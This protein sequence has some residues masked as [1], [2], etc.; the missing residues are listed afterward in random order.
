MKGT[1]MNEP[2]WVDDDA[3]EPEPVRETEAEYLAAQLQNMKNMHLTLRVQQEALLKGP[4]D[5][6]YPMTATNSRV[7]KAIEWWG[8]AINHFE[9]DVINGNTKRTK[10][11]QERAESHELS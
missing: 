2:E 7:T 10:V 8:E 9:Y 4:T 6:G 5:R 3:P 11:Q 1:E